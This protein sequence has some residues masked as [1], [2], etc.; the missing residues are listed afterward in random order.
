M[1]Q[2]RKKNV[3]GPQTMAGESRFVSDAEA[4]EARAIV[5]RL[6]T[7]KTQRDVAAMIGVSKT[8]LSLW[9]GAGKAPSR[10]AY[11]KILRHE[12]QG[13]S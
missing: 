13:G 1:Y 12:R 8:A 3:L 10:E 7:V 4:R 2:K 11:N 9:V 5:R 6:L